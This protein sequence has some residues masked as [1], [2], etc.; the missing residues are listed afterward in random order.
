M[1]L[2]MYDDLSASPMHDLVDISSRLKL[3]DKVNQAILNAQG[4]QSELKLGFYWQLLQY[5]QNQLSTI[6]FPKI[7]DPMELLGSAEKKGEDEDEG[8]KGGEGQKSKQVTF[9]I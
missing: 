5:S 4:Y 1:T 9:N 2:L 6:E 8:D 3:A 7:T